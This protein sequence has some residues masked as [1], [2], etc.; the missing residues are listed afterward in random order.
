MEKE[1]IFIRHGIAEDFSKEGDDYHRRLTERG[2]RRLQ[3]N[4]PVL[5]HFQEEK[6]RYRILSS[7]LLRA[8]ET[9]EILREVMGFEEEILFDLLV[10][11]GHL[12]KLFHR[13]LALKEESLYVV[14]HEPILSDWVYHLTG[15]FRPFKKGEAVSVILTFDQEGEV[16]AAK[17]RFA[18]T[19]EDMKK[20][21]EED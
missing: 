21:R 12:H 11:E 7:P 20:R 4:F 13:A 16:V 9:S 14:G 19:P 15:D 8:K 17:K 3:K 18:L 6:R 5:R 1:L 10:A 2:Q